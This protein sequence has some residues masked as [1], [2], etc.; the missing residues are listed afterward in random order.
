MSYLKKLERLLAERKEENVIVEIK[1]VKLKNSE[2]LK[3]V[4]ATIKLIN[5]FTKEE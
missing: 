5:D 4:S 2:T 3:K 1:K